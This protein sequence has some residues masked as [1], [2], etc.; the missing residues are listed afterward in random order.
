MIKEAG[1]VFGG[2]DPKETPRWLIGARKL[3]AAVEKAATKR[4]LGS[5]A[6]GFDGSAQVWLWYDSVDTDGGKAVAQT[7]LTVRPDQLGEGV[8]T[9]IS[10]V[11]WMGNNRSIAWTRRYFGVYLELETLERKESLDKFGN[12]LVRV[13]LRARK[14]AL[15]HAKRLPELITRHQE[16]MNDQRVVEKLLGN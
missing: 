16:L 3:E 6:G 8:E 9:D 14:G 11:A 13:L 2:L 12:S 1:P 15:A 10:A 5:L 7:R 4:G